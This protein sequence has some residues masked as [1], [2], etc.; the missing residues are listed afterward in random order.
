MTTQAAVDVLGDT[1]AGK[2]RIGGNVTI[3]YTDNGSTRS[4]ITDLSPLS[5][6]VRIRGSL[7]VQQNGQLV[8][9]NDLDNLQTIGGYFHVSTNG[10][11]TDLGDFPV[12]RYIGK[13]V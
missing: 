7:R 1:L 5:N 6:I 2:I 3:G 11:L 13:L 10:K 12:L 9:L 8:N 4:D